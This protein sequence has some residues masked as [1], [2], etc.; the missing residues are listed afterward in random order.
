[1]LEYYNI[2]IKDILVYGG[3]SYSKQLTH[4]ENEMQQ[5]NKAY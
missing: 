1:M 3:K 5:N 2:V 4:S